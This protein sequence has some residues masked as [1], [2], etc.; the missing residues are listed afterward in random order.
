MQSSSEFPQAAGK[1][2]Q[3]SSRHERA[4]DADLKG[5]GPFT[6]GFVSS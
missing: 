1:I 2:S 3:I 6:P 5:F 4:A